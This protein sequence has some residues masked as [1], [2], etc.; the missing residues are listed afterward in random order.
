LKAAEQI[1]S[2]LSLAAQL[3]E[4]EWRVHIPDMNV[5]ELKKRLSGGFRPFAI[6]TT[7]DQEFA[8]PHPEFLL[9]GKYSIA[10]RDK[11]GFI[12]TLDPLHIVSARELSRRNG[13]S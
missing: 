13:G 6:R 5:Q 7:D 12:N 4:V 8:I 9:I 11:K 2:R 3:D 1:Q 10:V